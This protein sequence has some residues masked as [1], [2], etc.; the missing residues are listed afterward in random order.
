MPTQVAQLRQSDSLGAECDGEFAPMM[1][2]MGQD[3]PDRPLARNG[4]GFSLVGLQVG[5]REI[6]D[7]PAVER[8]LDHLPGHLQPSNEFGGIFRDGVLGFQGRDLTRELGT[9]RSIHTM[10]PADTPKADMTRDLACRAQVW[11]GPPGQL[12]TRQRGNGAHQT[13]LVS[14]P[15]FVDGHERGRSCGHDPI[16]F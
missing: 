13:E 5:L 16:S 8:V 2:V 7:G 15:P 14:I 12:F 9:S 6:G 3:A 4:V 11:R 1:E 10:E